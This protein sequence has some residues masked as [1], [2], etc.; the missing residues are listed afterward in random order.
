MQP[1][2]YLRL[3]SPNLP[4]IAFRSPV[5]CLT[6]CFSSQ[7]RTV[8]RLASQCWSTD[9]NTVLL[10]EVP[11]L[12]RAVDLIRLDNCRIV[13][14]SLAVLL[15]H[16]NKRRALVKVVPRQTI[17]ERIALCH[18]YRD[19]GSELDARLSFPAHE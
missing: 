18:A 9:P 10:A 4:S 16:I 11:V 17:K 1:S 15:D 12:V 3:P 6:T 2:P 5:S 7:C 8:V 19:L 13:S 14:H